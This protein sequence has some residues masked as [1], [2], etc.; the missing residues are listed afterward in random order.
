MSVINIK[1][2]YWARQCILVK[3]ER[4][5]KRMHVTWI[6]EKY[7]KKNKYVRVRNLWTK[8][9]EDNWCVSKVFEGRKRQ[10]EITE[11]QNDYKNTRKA[12]DI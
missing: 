2:S 9:W 4:G 12:S 7:A 1:D 6:P 11:R 10:H 8:E 3:Y 5:N